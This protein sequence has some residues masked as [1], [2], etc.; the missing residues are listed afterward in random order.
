MR[1]LLDLYRQILDTGTVIHNTR[2]GKDCIMLP[3]AMLTFDLREGFPAVTTKKL[4]FD[5]VKGELLGF[6]RGY[7][8]AADFR[9]L[10]CNIW[11]KN[12]NDPGTPEA[13]NAWLT[14]PCRKG[15]DDLG[16]IYGKQWTDWE[17]FR[18][19]GWDESYELGDGWGDIA[20]NGYGTVY[21]KRINQLEEALRKIKNDPSNRRIIVTGWNPA[22]LDR[23]SLPACH[24]MYQFIADPERKLLHMTMWQRSADCF[25]GVPFNIASSAL[26]LSIMAR[27]A[28]Y[29]PATF[30]HF[31][32][33]AH[34]YADHIEQVK[35][36]LTREPLTLARLQLDIDPIYADDQIKGAFAR[37]EPHQIQLIGYQSHPPIKADMAI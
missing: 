9:A 18:F 31:M 17:A 3:G 16:P 14:N 23:V 22:D 37:I 24:V 36:Q 28:G 32:S 29:E 5:A 35:L 2:T 8:S 15:E 19:V 33:D 21:H 12:A 13:P 1:Q 30:T 27:L 10:G 7:T 4:Y 25:L 34:I 6:L 11:D 26:L 20:H